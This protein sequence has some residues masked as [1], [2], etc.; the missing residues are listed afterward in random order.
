MNRATR[1]SFLVRARTASDTALVF[2]SDGVLIKGQEE[3]IRRSVEGLG[4]C[5]GVF[6]APEMAAQA[7]AAMLD[8][9]PATCAAAGD[10]DYGRWRG[11]SFESLLKTDPDEL[12]QW[13][14]DPAAV[15]HGGESLAMAAHRVA[16]WMAQEKDAGGHRLVITHGMIVKLAMASVLDAPLTAVSRIDLPFLAVVSFR[17]DGRR[18]NLVINER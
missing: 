4:P 9:V 13:L 12:T 6:S 1:L 8:F 17:S 10:I 16:T 5:H 18:W 3:R 2:G 14:H 7:T 15:P 11:R